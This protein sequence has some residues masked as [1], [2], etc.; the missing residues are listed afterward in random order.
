M[1]RD[2][3]ERIT[4]KNRT[5]LVSRELIIDIPHGKR[6]YVLREVVNSYIKKDKQ[7]PQLSGRVIITS[8]LFKED[9]E[10]MVKQVERGR[11]PSV[12]EFVRC[13]LRD[14]KYGYDIIPLELPEPE[15]VKT[16]NIP[17]DC[18]LVPDGENNHI[19][20]RIVRRLE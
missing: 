16:I 8:Y 18:V 3:D 2:G 17:K 10:Y 4:K 6:S 12:S 15:P 1:Q 5:M 20:Y 14:W 13:A 7:F 19:I 9:I 11:F